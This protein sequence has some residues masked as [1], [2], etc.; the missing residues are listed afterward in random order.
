MEEEKEPGK[1]NVS[2]TQQNGEVLPLL[3][4]TVKLKV[5]FGIHNDEVQHKDNNK[6]E[7]PKKRKE[8]LWV[9]DEHNQNFIQWRTLYDQS[10]I[11]E[12]DIDWKW[13]EEI[14]TTI[15]YNHSW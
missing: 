6:W 2:E 5:T 4:W 9:T 8:K 7:V 1:E 15:S 12:R 10:K 14:F 3:R 11:K 13:A